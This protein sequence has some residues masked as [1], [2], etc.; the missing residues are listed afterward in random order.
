[1]QDKNLINPLDDEKRQQKVIKYQDEQTA[2]QKEKQIFDNRT[3][4]YKVSGDQQLMDAIKDTR[5][6]NRVPLILR[7]PKNSMKLSDIKPFLASAF[8]LPY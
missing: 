4:I 2:I 8:S 5:N 6:M 7:T 3:R 1:M